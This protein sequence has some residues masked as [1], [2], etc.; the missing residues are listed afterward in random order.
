[1]CTVTDMTEPALRTRTPAGDPAWLVTDYDL[2]RRLLAD[3]RL[4]RDH[5]DPPAAP[6]YSESALF[7]RPQP[8]SP[9]AAAD[10]ARMRRLLTPWFSARR[11]DALRPRVRELVGGLL[12]ELATAGPPADLHEAVSFPLPA[13]VI[14]ELL[15]VPYADRAD[16]RR[17]SDEAADMTDQQRSYAGLGALFGYLSELVAAKLDDPG[18]DVLSGLIE[19]HRADPHD[20]PLDA[21]AQLGAGLLFAGHE[22]TVAAIDKGVVLLATNPDQRAA[23]RAD[24]ALVEPAVEEILRSDIPT[25]P[26]G[27]AGTDTGLA[28][29]ASAEI[30][31]GAVRIAAGDLV[32][33]GLHQANES[34]RVVGERPGF[35][36][37]RR[38]NPH[39]TF[40]Y[41]ARF[42]IGA[43]LARLELRELFGALLQ[44]F[45]GLDLAV[46]VADLRPR[47]GRLTGGLQELPVTW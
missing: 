39:V 7:G 26:P 45:P 17:W 15:G 32:L 36:V 25:R 41:G 18:E 9:T 40:G 8:V 47:T 4:G 10:H 14:C 30:D 27:P 2:V 12:D 43:P 20:L 24:P 13:L 16:F 22:T 46:P 38:P 42:C 3:P 34:S 35:T 31:L 23:L 21:V 29:W 6:R 5:P 1:M 28:R 44:R 37:D 33:L 19:A 11:L